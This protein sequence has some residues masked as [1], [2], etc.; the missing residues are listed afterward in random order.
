[1][2]PYYTPK[3]IHTL[4]PGLLWRHT[5]EDK[6]LFLTFDDGPIPELT[7]YVLEELDRFCAKATFF[8][9]GDNIQKYPTQ[10]KKLISS[11][12]AVGNHTFN[13]LD[14]WKNTKAD[15]VEN[16]GKCLA[17]MKKNGYEPKI[18]LFRPPYGKIRPSQVKALSGS[19]K[20]VMW[21][22]LTN[23]FN[24]AHSAGFSLRQS[25][26]YTKDGSIIVFHDNLKAEKKLKFMLPMFLDHFRSHDFKFRSLHEVLP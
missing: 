18:K 15:Y 9:V 20:I 24:C 19:Y 21:D 22:V 10:F 1:M 12:H 13:H 7:E 14:G 3:F 2:A 4:F 11:G 6:Q 5:G 25:L 17:E 26:K 8:C 23:D 16:T